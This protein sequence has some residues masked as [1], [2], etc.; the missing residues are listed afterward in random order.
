M[1]PM[2][3]EMHA[4]KNVHTLLGCRPALYEFVRKQLD[5]E[6]KRLASDE[7]FADAIWEYEWYVFLLLLIYFPVFSYFPALALASA[8]PV[9]TGPP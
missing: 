1:S 3:L 7:E 4:C 6:G 8:A 2:E 5:Q 9:S